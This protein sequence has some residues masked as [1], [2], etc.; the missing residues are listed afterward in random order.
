MNAAMRVV[1]P[2]VSPFILGIG[3]AA[4]FSNQIDELAADAY[5]V[6][7]PVIEAKWSAVKVED[8]RYA[9]SFQGVKHKGDCHLVSIWAYDVSP[10]GVMTRLTA[11]RVDGAINQHYAAGP[12]ATRLP[13]ILTP[14]PLGKLAI[15]MEHR[16]GQRVVL[17]PVAA[18]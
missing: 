8:G 18:G 11:T 1:R 15:K 5:Y 12:F 2:Y 16:C 3:L 14:P 6:F 17:T 13:W 10:D 4:L 7:S 9:V